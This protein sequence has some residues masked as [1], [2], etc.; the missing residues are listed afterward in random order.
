MVFDGWVFRGEKKSWHQ[1]PPLGQGAACEGRQSTFRRVETRMSHISDNLFVLKIFN[2]T[3]CAVQ[4][5]TWKEAFNQR[6]PKTRYNKNVCKHPCVSFLPFIFVFLADL[7]LASCNCVD[8]VSLRMSQC[9]SFAN[10][11]WALWHL[12]RCAEEKIGHPPDTSKSKTNEITGRVQ[13]WHVRSEKK[14]ISKQNEPY[15][16]PSWTRI[17]NHDVSWH[18]DG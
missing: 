2:T 16:K 15:Q 11:H 17:M 18:W 10:G 4:T 3:V 7:L 6:H 9:A 12:W 13:W 8:C 1:I 5:T 14:N